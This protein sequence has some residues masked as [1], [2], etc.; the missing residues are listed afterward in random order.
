MICLLLFLLRATL[1]VWIQSFIGVGLVANHSRCK[2]HRLHDPYTTNSA[3]TGLLGSYIVTKFFIYY[4]YI[5]LISKGNISKMAF[6]CCFMTW[7]WFPHAILRTSL[8]S[9]IIVSLGCLLFGQ[10]PR[11]GRWPMLSH[12]WGIFSFSF[13]FFYVPPPQIPVSRPKF[14]SRGPN[15]SLE[16]HIPA[17]RPK[18]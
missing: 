7:K 1:N 6:L 10:R 5:A 11:R 9:C 13:S 16:A 15:P 18:S 8:S 12:I 17:S 4:V 2:H 14:Q 3:L